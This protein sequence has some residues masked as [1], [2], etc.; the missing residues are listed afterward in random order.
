MMTTM[1]PVRLPAKDQEG[2]A[3]PRL[4]AIGSTINGTHGGAADIAAGMAR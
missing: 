2:T 3:Q 4:R 1:P